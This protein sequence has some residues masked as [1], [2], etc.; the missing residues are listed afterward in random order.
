MIQVVCGDKAQEWF[1][2]S[3]SSRMITKN[4]WGVPVDGIH[5]ESL[6]RSWL[7]TGSKAGVRIGRD[8]HFTLE[9]L[10]GM[11]YEADR[12]IGMDV[13]IL[14]IKGGSDGRY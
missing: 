1:T 8:L 10:T 12:E 11:G 7:S 3:E 9:D 14:E 6:R 5:S 4:A 2:L 13:T